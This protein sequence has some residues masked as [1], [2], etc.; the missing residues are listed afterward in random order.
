MRLIFDNEINFLKEQLGVEIPRESAFMDRM[1]VKVLDNN[2][3]WHII[4]RIKAENM[5]L[6]LTKDNRELLD[7]ITIKSWNDLIKENEEH[8]IELENKSK[9]IVEE[10]LKEYP[11]H[12]PYV[13][14]SG[15]KDSAVTHYIV[16]LVTEEQTVF[17]NTSNET[18]HTYKYI[19]ENYPDAIKISPDEGFY[20][21]VQRTGFIPTRFGRACCTT[22]KEMPMIQK[23]PKDEKILFFMGMRK[24]ESNNRSK[25]SVKWKNTRWGSRDW[26]GVLPILEWSDMDVLLYMLY[27]NIPFN[28]LYT[29]GYGRVGCVNCCFRSDYELLLN[30]HFLT[31]YHDRWQLILEKDFINNKKAPTLN[32]TLEE[33]KNGAWK[34]GMVRDGATEEVINEFAR[35]QGLKVELAEKYFDKKCMCCG[36]KLKK[37]DV[38]ATMKFYGRLV[39]SFKC[40]GCI[41]KDLGIKTKELKD[42]LKFFKESG[43]D[44]F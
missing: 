32:C 18:H 7:N 22:Q 16:N 26:Q 24:A 10:H 8:L 31:P 37:D 44:L 20:T 5:N 13:P 34:A 15:G 3:K 40:C 38:A 21:F 14:V 1:C 17:S 12:K 35:Q 2:D 36:K 27:R 25:Y 39:E 9:K 30:K 4:Y 23:L 11:N 6:S 42:K 19:N 41:A 43:C 29:I 33:Y 28:Y